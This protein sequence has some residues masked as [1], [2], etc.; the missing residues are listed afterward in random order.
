MID[1]KPFCGTQETRYYLL[2]PFSRG[3]FTYAT[4]GHICVRVARRDDAPEQEIPDVTSLS[5]AER[6]YTPLPAIDLPAVSMEPCMSCYDGSF[7]DCPD[8]QCKCEDCNGTGETDSDI[9]TSINLIGRPFALRYVRLIAAL[10]NTAI[11]AVDDKTIAFRFDGGEG[12][13][14]GLHKPKKNHIEDAS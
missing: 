5:W 8:C 2:K 10:P 12:L 4:D 7:H 14:K 13:L 11:A 1:L 3:D 6:E 9:K